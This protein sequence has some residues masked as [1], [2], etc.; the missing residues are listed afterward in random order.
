MRPV[1]ADSRMPKGAMSL[2]KESILTGLA[3]LWGKVLVY[4]LAIMVQD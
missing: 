1:R 3:E 4:V 2:R